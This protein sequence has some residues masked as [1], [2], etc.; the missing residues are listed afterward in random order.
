MDLLWSPFLESNMI[1]NSSLV[2]CCP[3]SYKIASILP[4]LGAGVRIWHSCTLNDGLPVSYQ[5]D[6]IYDQKVSSVFS[7]RHHYLDS[8]IALPVLAPT[9][10]PWHSPVWVSSKICIFCWSLTF[11]LCSV[12]GG[13]RKGRSLPVELASQDLSS[14]EP[15]LLFPS[16]LAIFSTPAFQSTSRPND[17][18]SRYLWYWSMSERIMGF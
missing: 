14:Q 2:N 1:L 15:F 16:S 7:Q 18:G 12:L 5:L 6:Q 8:P 17:N 9:L 13:D 11:E 3:D 10:V 4:P